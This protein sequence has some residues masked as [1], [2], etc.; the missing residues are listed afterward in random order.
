M[1]AD[2]KN[3]AS[4]T[5]TGYIAGFEDWRGDVLN[6]LR[7]QIGKADPSLKE[8]FKWGVPVWSARANVLAISG[9]KNHVKI[10][11]FKGAE[12][13][14]PDGL[15]NAGLDAKTMRSIDLREGD[16]IDEKALDRLVR[17]AAALDLQG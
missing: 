17:A 9:F 8:E 7:K 2:E 10:N 16:E 14:D 6:R 1:P 3:S 13:E 5:I 12:L 15:F 4:T 11:F